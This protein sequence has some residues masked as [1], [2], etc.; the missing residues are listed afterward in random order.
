MEVPLTVIVKTVVSVPL[1]EVVTKVP[2][3]RPEDE[4]GAL[5][6]SVGVA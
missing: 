2:V 4:D 5:V 3:R 1:V 6:S